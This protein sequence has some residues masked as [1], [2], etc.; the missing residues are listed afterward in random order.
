MEKGY[1]ITKLP[2]GTVRL[3]FEVTAG[4]LIRGEVIRNIKSTA[5]IRGLKISVDEDKGFFDSVYFVTATGTA[6]NVRLWGKDLKVLME[7]FA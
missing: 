7:H 1:K 6:E 3:D 5:R 4:A 2:D